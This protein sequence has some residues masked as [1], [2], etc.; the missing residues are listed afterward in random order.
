MP[1]RRP[2]PVCLTL[3][4]PFLNLI[5]AS[6]LLQSDN[7]AMWVHGP[8]SRTMPAVPAGNYY[9]FQGQSQQPAGLRQG[10]QPSQHFGGALGYPN[11]YQSTGIS[12]EQQQQHQHQQQMARDG[13]LI[14][15]HSQ[16]QQPKQPPQLWQNT[17]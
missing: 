2:V 11:F 12:L 7:S 1:S 5:L 9:N 8:G 16:G 17:Y 3:P 13:T 6:V 10:Q 15:A 14:G 4:P